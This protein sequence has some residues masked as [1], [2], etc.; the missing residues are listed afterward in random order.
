[1]LQMKPQPGDPN[2]YHVHIPDSALA[3][4]MWEG[5]MG[6]YGQFCLDFYDVERKASVNLPRGYSL[7]PAAVPSVATG[8]GYPPPGF[9]M[10]LNPPT[11]APM[12]GPLRSWERNMGMRTIPEGEEKWMVPEGMYVTL[13]RDGL[14]DMTFQTP[15]RRPAFVALQPQLGPM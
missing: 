1:S 5:G 10:A 4:R 2:V 6:P 13:K 9:P 12:A 11:F 7:H 8:P 3:I 15:T 14:P